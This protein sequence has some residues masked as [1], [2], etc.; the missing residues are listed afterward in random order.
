MMAGRPH[1]AEAVRNIARHDGIDGRDDR[2]GRSQRRFCR[3]GRHRCVRIYARKLAV[4]NFRQEYGVDQ[5]LVVRCQE[6]AAIRL[7]R[8]EMSEPGK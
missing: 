7:G 2:A 4:R 8:L 3:T 5:R 1:C 6:R